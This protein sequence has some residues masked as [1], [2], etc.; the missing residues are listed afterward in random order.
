MD[1]HGLTKKLLIM[2]AITLFFALFFTS[3]AF[4]WVTGKVSGTCPRYC[5]D[6]DSGSEFVKGTIYGYD[7]KCQ[8]FEK[9]DYCS[10]DN[11]NQL[12]EYRCDTQQK[13]NWYSEIVTCEH[14]CLDGA[15]VA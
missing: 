7:A 2:C 11:K 10:Q 4:Q 12:K 8:K 14:G 13:Q 9:T 6:S 5:I 1:M 15:C 3:G